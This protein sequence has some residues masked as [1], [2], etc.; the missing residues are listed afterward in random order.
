MRKGASRDKRQQSRLLRG[1]REGFEICTVDHLRGG[2]VRLDATVTYK[3][4]SHEVP[5][6]PARLMASRGWV[7][8]GLTRTQQLSVP[9]YAPSKPEYP[10]GSP[11]ALPTARPRRS[12]VGVFSHEH[13][14]LKSDSFLKVYSPSEGDAAFRSRAPGTKGD[15]DVMK[16]QPGVHKDMVAWFRLNCGRVSA[17]RF[18]TQTFTPTPSL[19]RMACHRARNN[20]TEWLCVTFTESNC[21]CQVLGINDNRLIEYEPSTLAPLG[22]VVGADELEGRRVVVVASGD[23][24]DRECNVGESIGMEVGRLAGREVESWGKGG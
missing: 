1:N 23:G 19:A 8:G 18:S 13:D 17:R 7:G 20:A 11:P 6:L 2:V 15:I 21:A 3:D 24:S 12:Q 5:S 16:G 10:L 14:E 4:F 22:L 9:P